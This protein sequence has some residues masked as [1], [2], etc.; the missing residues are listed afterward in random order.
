MTVLE[1]ALYVYMQYISIYMSD[2]APIRHGTA[3]ITHGGC[4]HLGPGDQFKQFSG[5]RVKG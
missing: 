1:Y 3:R 4:F 2:K 5:C